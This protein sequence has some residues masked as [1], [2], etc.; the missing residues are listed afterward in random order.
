MIKSTCDETGGNVRARTKLSSTGTAK[1]AGGCATTTEND[2]GGGG[3]GGGSCITKR[4]GREFRGGC[5]PARVSWGR[6]AWWTFAKDAADNTD[7]AP[8]SSRVPRSVRI[9]N[10]IYIYCI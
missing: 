4:S 1:A 8:E 3:G 10:I 7:G 9:V 5:V 6:R 2:G